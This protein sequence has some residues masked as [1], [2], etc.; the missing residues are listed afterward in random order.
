M[1][2]TKTK[3][4]PPPPG[5][6][7]SVCAIL[8]ANLCLLHQGHGSVRVQVPDGRAAV[9]W[10][11]GGQQRVRKLPHHRLWEVHLPGG[12]G[13][14]GQHGLLQRLHLQGQ[15]RGLLLQ[16]VQGQLLEPH[17]RQC[18]WVPAMWMWPHRG[19]RCCPMRSYKWSVRLPA[20]QDWATLWWLP[21]RSV[22]LVTG[23][24][25]QPKSVSLL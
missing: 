17:H 6:W 5:T 16:H 12:W 7:V 10:V 2:N 13:R 15:C 20:Q 8:K 22:Q 14:R 3:S 19:Q 11:P 18:G 24:R 23:L 1:C 4:V 21:T 25:T 9:Q